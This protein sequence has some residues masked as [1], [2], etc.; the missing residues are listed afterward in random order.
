LAGTERVNDAV[1]NQ[2]GTYY[3]LLYKDKNYAAEADYV[4]A[5][6]RKASP[7]VRDLLEFGAG[8]GRHGRLLARKG[9]SVVGIENSEPMVLSAQ[10]ANETTD[11]VGEGTFSCEV[12]DIRSF[13]INMK[14]DAVISLFHVVSY[15]TSNH[16]LLKVFANAARHL[17]RHGLFFFDV[18]HG[19][20]VLAQKPAVR[21]KK[22]EDDSVRLIRLAE[23]LM[24]AVAHI[25]TVTYTLFVESKQSGKLHRFE[26]RHKVRYFFPIEIEGLANQT[27]FSVERSEEFLTGAI[28]SDKTW[29]VA[30]LLR[31]LN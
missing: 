5:T 25:V 28:L 12:G 2:Y 18:W 15:Q 10:Q 19:P 16:D 27:G 22:A 20:A 26:E 29:G 14:F 8:T 6:L 31:K 3:D 1:F 7:N 9:F 11:D 4:A 21:V 17:K 23:P 13:E 24:D 30:Y